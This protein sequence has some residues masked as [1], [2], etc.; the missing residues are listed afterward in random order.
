MKTVQICLATY[1]GGS[2]ISS[3]LD[4]LVNQDLKDFEVLI[5]DD[6][7]IDNTVDIIRSYE[8]QLNIVFHMNGSSTPMGSAQNFMGL[9][10]VSSADYVLLADQDDV[11]LSGKVRKCLALMADAEGKNHIAPIFVFSD[12]C[13]VD[14]D[15]CV[16]EESGLCKVTTNFSVNK[17]VQSLDYTN[18]IP[19]CTVTVNRRLVDL[20]VNLECNSEILMHDWWLA[21]IAKYNRGIFLFIREPLVMYRQH[22]NN[23]VGVSAKISVAAKIFSFLRFPRKKL[24]Q[25]KKQFKMAANAGRKKSFLNFLILRFSRGVWFE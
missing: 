11:W 12:Y 18:F 21:L 20:A 23:V 24:T 9:L 8:D 2:F 14:E 4:S 1:N 22:S 13:V 10:K 6:G 17:L 15:L 19:G 7:S 16:I 25:L 5:S 3:F